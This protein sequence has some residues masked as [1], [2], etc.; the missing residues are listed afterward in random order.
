MAG[1]TEGEL[2][3]DYI[4]QAREDARE[5]FQAVKE[6]ART[7]MIVGTVS[8]SSAP[9]VIRLFRHTLP[10]PSFSDCYFVVRSSAMPHRKSKRASRRRT[11]KRSK[12]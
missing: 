12:I 8:Y 2:R 9:H 11:K 3:K 4:Q 6:K 10:P 7:D 1:K 5:G